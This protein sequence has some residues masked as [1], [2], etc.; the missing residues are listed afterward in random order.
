MLNRK[1]PNKLRKI[2]DKELEPRESITWVEQPIPRLFTLDSIFIFIFSIPWT[3]FAVYWMYEA[4][5]SNIPDL[6]EGIKPE[7]IFALFGVPFILV[8]LWMLSSPIR[9]WLKAFRTV[10]IITNKR[11]ISIEDGWFTI[12]KSYT[13]D[14]LKNVY[15]QQKR[16]GIGNVIITTRNVRNS[17][18]S[19]RTEEI[20]FMN[21]RQAKEVEIL[22]KKLADRYVQE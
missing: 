13:P 20:G 14:Q 3:A 6:R 12:I 2:I 11:A 18:G 15:R 9:V 19:L 17:E 21:V 4:A 22:L 1:I 10:Y 16:N 8:G 7:Y 5:G